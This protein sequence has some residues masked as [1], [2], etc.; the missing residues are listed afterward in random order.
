MIKFHK[1]MSAVTFNPVPFDA[2]HLTV[3]FNSFPDINM[4][5]LVT[6]EDLRRGSTVWL[7]VTVTQPHS[8]TCALKFAR[9]CS[10]NQMLIKELDM[11]HFLYPDFPLSSTWRSSSELTH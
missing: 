1:E 4:K 6:L 9:K 11:W 10:K 8:A 5:T 7:C 3:D 2:V